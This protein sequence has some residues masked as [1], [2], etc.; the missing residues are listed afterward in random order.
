MPPRRSAGA[1]DDGP[2]RAGVAITPADTDLADETSA[3]YVGGT[4]DVS[5]RFPGGADVVFPGVPAGTILPIAVIRV[6]AATTA[7]DIVGL[8]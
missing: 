6:N 3:L 4:G 8:W 1:N 5:V 2:A 7:T